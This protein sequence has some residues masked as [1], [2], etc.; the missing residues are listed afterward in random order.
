MAAPVD[1]KSKP[2]ISDAA[3]PSILWD[4]NISTADVVAQT[5]PQFQQQAKNFL[6]AVAPSGQFNIETFYSLFDPNGDGHFSGQEAAKII[7][8]SEEYATFY[9]EYALPEGYD[10][11]LR[12]R[13]ERLSPM[14]CGLMELMQQDQFF[15]D[16]GVSL[17]PPPQMTIDSKARTV[18]KI[19]EGISNGVKNGM[20]PFGIEISTHSKVSV[21]LSGGIVSD[22][23]GSSSDV[24]EPKDGSEDD[25]EIPPDANASPIDE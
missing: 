5:D 20:D 25:F 9:P 21:G 6:N 22:Y 15:G 2:V 14:L 16:L 4:G 17:P 10:P 8:G 19:K 7:A 3:P 1:N 13:C 18:R 12:A 24:G 11:A 23:I